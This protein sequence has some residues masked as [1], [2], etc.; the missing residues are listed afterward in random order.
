ME[1]SSAELGDK[2]E[3]E[4]MDATADGM[5]TGDGPDAIAATP[6]SAQTAEG[7]EVIILK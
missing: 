2:G 7:I 6:L 3:G 5:N 4:V 1:S